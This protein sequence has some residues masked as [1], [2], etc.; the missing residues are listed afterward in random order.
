MILHIALGVLSLAVNLG[1]Q[2]GQAVVNFREFR[3]EVFAK[4]INSLTRKREAKL[5]R[6]GRLLTDI[7]QMATLPKKCAIFPA[8]MRH[9][10]A[11]ERPPT[12]EARASRRIA[13]I[14]PAL[15]ALSASN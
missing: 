10:V 14:S 4:L 15:T 2:V 7:R 6:E 1:F 13:W 9:T 12:A 8:T 5:A 3:A 11:D